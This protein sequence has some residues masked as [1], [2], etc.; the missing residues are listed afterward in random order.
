MTGTGRMYEEM[1]KAY[2]MLIGKIQQKRKTGRAVHKSENIE[3][4]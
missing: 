2:R 3:I 4:M 1:V